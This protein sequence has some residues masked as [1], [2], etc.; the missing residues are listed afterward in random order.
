MGKELKIERFPVFQLLTSDISEL[1]YNLFSF[2]SSFAVEYI[3]SVLCEASFLM[4][5]RGVAT[6]GCKDIC[7]LTAIFLQ[8][9][10]FLSDII[11]TFYVRGSYVI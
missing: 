9:H 3:P 7:L 8:D 5:L 4:D 6:H 10:I 1:P 11:W 2:L